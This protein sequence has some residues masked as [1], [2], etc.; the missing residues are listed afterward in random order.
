MEVARKRREAEGPKLEN[1]TYFMLLGEDEADM[2]AR[3]RKA[4]EFGTNI[5][6]VFKWGLTWRPDGSVFTPH[7]YPEL[8]SP[9]TQKMVRMAARAAEKEGIAI[10]G[11]TGYGMAKTASDFEYYGW[12]MIRYPKREHRRNWITACTNSPYADAYV[13]RWQELVKEYHWSGMQMESINIPFYCENP[14]HGCGV[15]GEDGELRGRYPIFAA[16]DF[17]IRLYNVFHG[18][19]IENGAMTSWHFAMGPVSAFL[20]YAYLGE[21]IYI[22]NAEHLEDFSIDRVRVTYPG[23]E[24]GLP[25][26]WIAKANKSKLKANGSLAFVLLH[27]FTMSD[28]FILDH[29][30]DRTYEIAT[31]K[32][33]TPWVWKAEDWIDARPNIFHPYWKNDEYVSVPEDTYA[34][35]YLQKGRKMLLVVTN[36]KPDKRTVPVRLNLGKLGF[37]GAT[38]EGEDAVTGEKLDISSNLELE[39]VRDRFRLIKIWRE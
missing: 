16:R 5:I 24:F 8:A 10:A 22:M 38:L 11:H 35:F 32:A 31:K 17:I 7:D 3:M 33:A 20:D 19:G 39:V 14:Y 29:L 6:N 26:Y 1:A 23:P 37:R 18:E 28:S 30:D 36:W 25:V 9:R 12:E 2:R 13:T 4:K 27:G 21:E 34:S 15:E